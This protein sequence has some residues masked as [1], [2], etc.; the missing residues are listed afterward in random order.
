MSTNTHC[1]KEPEDNMRMLCTLKIK[2]ALDT[3]LLHPKTCALSASCFVSLAGHAGSDGEVVYSGEENQ[4]FNY[5]LIYSFFMC[6]NPATMPQNS[7]SSN[8]NARVPQ[9]S[10]CNIPCNS[11]SEPSTYEPFVYGYIHTYI[12][13]VLKKEN[14]KTKAM[15]IFQG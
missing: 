15:T 8:T 1:Y 6:R 10:E 12:H 5:N 11:L 4:C 9:F 2:D 3:L 13:I 14:R 7:I